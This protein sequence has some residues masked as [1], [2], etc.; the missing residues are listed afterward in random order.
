VDEGKSIGK[1]TCFPLLS[2]LGVVLSKECCISLE[3]MAIFDGGDC[4]DH[5]VMM[6]IRG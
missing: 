4:N 5:D 2:I 6:K 3:I 1:T